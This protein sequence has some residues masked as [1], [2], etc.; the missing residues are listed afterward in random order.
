MRIKT[1]L[2]VEIEIIFNLSN[3]DTIEL[4]LGSNLKHSFHLLNNH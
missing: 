1:H 4:T 3:N 2:F